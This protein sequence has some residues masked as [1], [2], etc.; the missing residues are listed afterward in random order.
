MRTSVGRRSRRSRTRRVLQML[1][2]RQCSFVES[3]RSRSKRL[4]AALPR[5]QICLRPKFVAVRESRHTL[6]TPSGRRTMERARAQRIRLRQCRS[7]ASAILENRTPR[8]AIHLIVCT[9]DHELVLVTIASAPRRTLRQPST[10]SRSSALGEH[11]VPGV[12]PTRTSGTEALFAIPRTL[13]AE[14]SLEVRRRSNAASSSAAAARLAVA[15]TPA[16]N[17]RVKLHDR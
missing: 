5:L 9:G 3:R 6:F 15:T 8:A 16:S 4:Q 17:E 11:C 2:Q 13:T 14:L 12:P 1:P 7:R 10:A